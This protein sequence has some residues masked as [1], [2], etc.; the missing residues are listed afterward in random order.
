MQRLSLVV[1]DQFTTT[2]L[3]EKCRQCKSAQMEAHGAYW[4]TRDQYSKTRLTINQENLVDAI[5]SVARLFEQLIDKR[6]LRHE[7]RA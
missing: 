6:F 3:D 4:K 5:R 1:D 2:T 7:A